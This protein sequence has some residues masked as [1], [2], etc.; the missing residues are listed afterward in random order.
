[1][2]SSS[3]SSSE[4]TLLEEM[5]CLS[6]Y[7]LSIYWLRFSLILIQFAQELLDIDLYVH[8]VSAISTSYV[9]AG[10]AYSTHTRTHNR[11]TYPCT[12]YLSVLP[13]V[14]I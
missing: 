7:Y 13:T 9:C 1:M 11:L 12:L 6:L 10:T 3:S 14:L 5:L 8:I 2:D 4:L